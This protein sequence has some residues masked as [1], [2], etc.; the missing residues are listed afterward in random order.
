MVLKRMRDTRFSIFRA[1]LTFF[2]TVEISIKMIYKIYVY[3]NNDCGCSIHEFLLF[4][5]E[6][7]YMDS[8]DCT[9]VQM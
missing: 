2:L 6:A 8:S 5:L 3:A 1:L 4:K 7:L 9:F